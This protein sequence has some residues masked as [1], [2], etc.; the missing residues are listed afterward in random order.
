MSKSLLMSLTKGLDPL[1]VMYKQ[2]A[3]DWK[4]IICLITFTPLVP[5]YFVVGFPGVEIGSHVNEWNL[6]APEL[7]PI[8]QVKPVS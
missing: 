4:G 2:N 1:V 7:F 3:V 5:P 6:N 8:F